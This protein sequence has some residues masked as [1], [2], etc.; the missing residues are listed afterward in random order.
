MGASHVLQRGNPL[1]SD[2]SALN[3]NAP[4][5]P[6]MPG[7]LNLGPT[8]RDREAQ[9]LRRVRELEEEA[10]LLRAENEKQVSSDLTL[11]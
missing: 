9:L 6:P 1:V 3:L 5:V 7:A 2:L 11:L 4:P 10:R 8:G